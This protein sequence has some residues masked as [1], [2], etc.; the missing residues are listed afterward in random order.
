MEVAGEEV[1][2]L[3]TLRSP[4]LEDHRAAVVGVA[5]QQEGA[6]LTFQAFNV[7]LQIGHLVPE[8]LAL[9]ALCL[10]GQFPGRRQVILGAA[11]RPPYGQDLLQ[12][13][14]PAS[15][16]LQLCGVPDDRR[17]GQPGFDLRVLGL[18]GLYLFTH[19]VQGTDRPPAGR[20]GRQLPGTARSGPF[21]A[22]H[23]TDHVD[24]DPE[25]GQGLFHGN[26]DVP[27]REGHHHPGGRLAQ[28][29]GGGRRDDL[30]IHP[31]RADH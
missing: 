28:H 18:Q 17:I 16:R 15:R 31:H 27:V 12:F 14:E 8:E 24:R 22:A 11:Q 1:G 20:S 6:Q 2:F 9:V 25:A 23:H 5:G 19:C 29:Q 21:P 30:W 13:L 10:L 3:A 26:Q 7:G 4:D